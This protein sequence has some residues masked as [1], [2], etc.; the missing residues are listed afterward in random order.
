MLSREEVISFPRTLQELGG[1]A[2]TTS[3]RKLIKAT[4][5]GTAPVPLSSQGSG[6]I[7][8]VVPPSGGQLKRTSG[9]IC[10]L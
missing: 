2:D 5:N 4:H 10:A 6:P 7:P 9:D 8:L 3:T 1:A